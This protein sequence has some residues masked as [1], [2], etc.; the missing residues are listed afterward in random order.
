MHWNWS[1]DQKSR[2]NKSPGTDGFA[3]EFYQTFREELMPILLKTL[4]KNY[5]GR[6]T[7]KLILQDHHH[8][9]TKARQ[10]QHRK[11]KPQA[12]ITDEH[13]CKNPQQ[14]FSKQN[15]A[16]HQKAYTLWSSWVYSRDAKIL[17]YMQI[18]QRDIPC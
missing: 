18:N 3:A 10:R 4:S 11:R 13:R 16:T 8:P 6:N 2:R 1:C 12:N 15:S 5:R 17:Q 14:K 9:D 7:S